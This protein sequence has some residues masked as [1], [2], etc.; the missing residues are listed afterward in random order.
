MHNLLSGAWDLYPVL[1]HFELQMAGVI[2]LS[3]MLVGGITMWYRRRREAAL[4]KDGAPETIDDTFTI[5]GG[6][7]TASLSEGDVPDGIKDP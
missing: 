6:S 5:P 2:L 3:A 4:S 7:R 1:Y